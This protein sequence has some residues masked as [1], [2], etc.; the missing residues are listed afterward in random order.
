MCECVCVSVYLVDT[1]TH[2]M[3]QLRCVH[4]CVEKRPSNEMDWRSIFSFIKASKQFSVNS[5]SASQHCKLCICQVRLLSRSRGHHW[6]SE[7]GKTRNWKDSYNVIMKPTSTPKL[8]PT[9][10]LCYGKSLQNRQQTARYPQTL[11]HTHTH[12]HWHN[13]RQSWFCCAHTNIQAYTHTC[14]RKVSIVFAIENLRAQRERSSNKF[15]L[16]HARKR[17][18]EQDEER[19]C[20]IQWKARETLTARA[21]NSSNSV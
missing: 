7:S 8:K 5:S 20:F 1:D 2:D 19:A 17:G 11:S 3:T 15:A 6:Q 9:S 16:S 21:S 13:N 4:V 10:T 18:T 12:T 14:K